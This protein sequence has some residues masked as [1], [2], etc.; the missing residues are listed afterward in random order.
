MLK[1]E[2]KIITTSRISKGKVY[3]LFPFLLI[4]MF[5]IFSVNT[6]K[7]QSKPDTIVVKE[8]HSPGKA[9]LMSTLL[10]GLGQVY[11]KQYWKVPVLYA[12][13]ATLTYFLITNKKYADKFSTEYTHRLNKDTVGLNPEYINYSTESVLQLRDYNQRNYEFTIIL[14]CAVY[15]LNIIDASVY[16][17]LFSF[18]VGE[19]LSLKVEPVIYNSFGFSN[20]T[21][22]GGFKLSLRF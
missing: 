5:N 9:A 3:L 7:A 6:S 21:P 16:G 14:S 12:G 20:Y 1:S 13:F 11:N 8:I 4:F 22:S 15:I 19:N 17:H 2:L 10:P 18:D